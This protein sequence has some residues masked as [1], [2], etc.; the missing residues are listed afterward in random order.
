MACVNMLTVDVED[1]FQ[2]EKYRGAIPRDTWATRELRVG[3]MVDRLLEVFAQRGVHGTFFVLGWVA[4]RAPDLVGRIADAGHE[5]ASHGWSHTAIWD[6]DPASFA[7]EIRRSRAILAEQS[8][9]PILGYRAPTFSVT[10]QTL[11]ALDALVEAGY[12]YDSSIYPIRHD[13]YGIP[14]ARTEIHQHENGLWEVPMSVWARGD[15][16]VPF[17]GGGYLRLY[18]FP[19]TTHALKSLN[20]RGTPGV[21]Y[22]HPWEFDVDQP[23]VE[24]V[25]V[26]KTLRH[27]VGIR[28]NLDKVARLVEAFPFA[29]M[30]EVLAARGMSAPGLAA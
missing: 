30:G 21:V 25:S 7:D 15:L 29:P 24:G 23:R 1:W 27:H 22:L 11:W 10:R 13:N 28:R 16:R 19:F 6:L 3:R 20:A 8:G 17:G 26:L 9:Q 5:I 14:D 2:V 12:A 18:P 4:E